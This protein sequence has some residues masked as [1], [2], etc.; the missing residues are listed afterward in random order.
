MRKSKI[1]KIDDLEVTVKELRVRDIVE[2]FNGSDDD[3]MLD[4][5]DEVLTRCTDIRREQLM[6]MTPT[7][8][9]ILWDG[10]R[11][12]NSAFLDLAALVGLDDLPGMLRNSL[13]SQFALSS[14]PD[15]A[16]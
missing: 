2:L 14:V 10:F 7:D 12:V 1:I 13:Q 11:E 9:Q 15:T 16:Q 4:R 8:L 6:D 5:F 3:P